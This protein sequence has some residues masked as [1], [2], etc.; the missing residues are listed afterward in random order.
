[1]L[2]G[3]QQTEIEA[4]LGT[5]ER[6]HVKEAAAIAAAKQE[7]LQTLAAGTTHLISRFEEQ[8]RELAGA[9]AELQRM[10]LLQQHNTQSLKILACSRE[11]TQ[12]ATMS[13]GI[14]P[15]LTLERD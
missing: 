4:E 5:A 15:I 9:K 8:A 3:P 7:Q 14:N 13:S 11:S 6:K 1:M 2:F 12:T 10:A